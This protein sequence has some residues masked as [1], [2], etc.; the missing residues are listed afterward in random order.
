MLVRDG[1]PCLASRPRR[2]RKLKPGRENAARRESCLDDFVLKEQVADFFRL[3][4]EIRDGTILSLE[5][6]NGLPAHMEIEEG[7]A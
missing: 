6:Q 3:L 1:R 5:V 7:A 4:A 2:I